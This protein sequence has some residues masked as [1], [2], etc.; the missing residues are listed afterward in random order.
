MLK[1]QHLF[2]ALLFFLF[3]YLFGYHSLDSQIFEK[4]HNSY[5]NFWENVRYSC[6]GHHCSSS[7]EEWI[8]S[9]QWNQQ[10]LLVAWRCLWLPDRNLHL[11]T[12]WYYRQ[13]VFLQLDIKIWATS[14][15]ALHPKY[16][17]SDTLHFHQSQW[18]F[19]GLGKRGDISHNVWV[20]RSWYFPQF[21]PSWSKI[22]YFFCKSQ[23]DELMMW[24]I[25]FIYEALFCVYN[26]TVEQF[27]WQGCTGG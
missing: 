27:L 10:H 4:R 19:I 6:A 12:K 8:W 3:I 18:G 25:L 1:P 21:L 23:V 15:I 24:H 14:I 5:W 16:C 11:S 17:I 22:F 9:L 13:L 7:L 26:L 20:S 2:A